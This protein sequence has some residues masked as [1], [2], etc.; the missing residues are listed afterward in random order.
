VF[1]AE[2]ERFQLRRE[3]LPILDAGSEPIRVLHL[4]D[5]HLAPWHSGAISWIKALAE[6]KPDLVIGTGD[7]LGHPQG[8]SAV[9]E[10]L[11]PLSGIPGVVTHGSN[12]RHAPRWK[13]P[14]GYLLG[15]SRPGAE[16]GTALGLSRA[17]PA[18]T[19]RCWVGTTSITRRCA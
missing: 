11:L 10:A 8:L 5:L 2:R 7:F 14:L 13:N 9:T 6:T 4:S 15:P 12:D 19:R 17:S 16:E 3:T 1:L 18:S